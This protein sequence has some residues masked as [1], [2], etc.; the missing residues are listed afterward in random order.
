[1]KRLRKSTGKKLRY[2]HCGEYGPK[3]LRP[4]YHAI[5]FNLDFDDKVPWMEKEGKITYTSDTLEKI[6]GMGFCTT[7][8]VTFQSANY[9]AQYCMKKVTG[10]QAETHYVRTDPET[11]EQFSVIPE[12]ATMSRRPGVGHAWIQKHRRDVYRDDY[13]IHEGIR[14]KPP[15]YYDAQE[16]NIEEIKRKRKREAKNNPDNT[17]DRL[18]VREKIRETRI[19]NRKRDAI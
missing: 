8:D 3:N 2:F 19:Q 11:G 17:S 13:I 7:S 6:W 12:Y 14:M 18:R 10:E 1:M 15:K 4:H 5:I 16:E 9:V